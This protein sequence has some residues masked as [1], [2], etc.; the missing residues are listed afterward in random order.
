MPGGKLGASAIGA[1]RLFWE[2][3]PWTPNFLDPSPTVTEKK[4]NYDEI[5]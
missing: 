2:E 4:K 5:T 3:E 1:L